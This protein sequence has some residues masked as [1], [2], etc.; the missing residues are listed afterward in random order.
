MQLRS[1]LAVACLGLAVAA[2]PPPAAA[3]SK[4]H[5]SIF[6]LFDLAVDVAVVKVGP[7]PGP[8]YAG[9]VALRVKQRLKGAR[10]GTITARETNTSCATGFRGGRTALVFIGADRWP[11]GAYEGYL[12]K[13]SPAVV[14]TLTAWAQPQPEVDRAGLLVAAIAGPERA[15][16]RDAAWHLVDHPEL[17]AALTA[18]HTAALV[19]ARGDDDA[20][21]LV[22][23]ILA[24]QHGPAWRDLIAAGLP[25]R[26]P[27]L[28]VLAAHDLERVTD[29]GALAD[30]IAQTPGERAPERIAAFERCERVHGR[31]LEAFTSYSNGHAEHWWLK[32]A[33]ACRTGAPVTW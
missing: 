19:A 20:G 2:A 17:I 11:A 31:L 4:R 33:E 28:T 6:E 23:M 13:P 15:L 24:R 30:L 14:A 16:R 3:C 1:L 8:R 21:R 29:A 25:P 18:D 9:R 12:E 32:L 22:A 7:V 10:R 26:T 5:Q 27:A